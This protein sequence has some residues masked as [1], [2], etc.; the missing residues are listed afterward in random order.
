MTQKTTKEK[1]LDFKLLGRIYKLAKPYKTTLRVAIVLTIIQS[2]FFGIQPYMVQIA[3]DK[4]VAVGDIGGITMMCA[5]MLV[6]LLMQTS[7]MFFTGYLTNLLGQ[8]IIKNLRMYVFDHLMNLKVKFFDTNPV[9]MLITRTVSDIETI[10]EL[11]ASGLVTILGDLFQ[12]IV[13]L[14]CMFTMNWKLALVSLSILPFLLYASHIFR[15]KVKTSFQ[16]VRF[17]ISKLNS[18]IQEHISGMLVVQMFNREKKELDKFV[19]INQDHRDANIRGVFY[20]A[21]FFPVVEIIVALTFAL[22][23]WYGSIGMFNETVEFGQLTAFIMFINL[24]FRPIRAIA[25]RFNNIQMGMVAADRIFKLIDD[26]QYT[27]TQG[28]IKNDKFTNSVEFKDVWL[29]YNEPEYVL[30]GVSFKVNQGETLA[31]VGPTGSGKTS[32]ISLLSRFYDFQ[33]GQILIDDVD[34]QEMDL[35]LLRKNVA[36]VLQDVFLF[37]GSITDNIRLKNEDITQEQIEIAAKSIGAYDFIDSLPG[38]FEYNV[39][40]R[41]AA[42]SLGQ[43]QLISFIR[44]LAFNP[45]L[46]VLDEATSSVDSQT[47]GLIQNAIQLLLKGRTSIV[48]AHRL[49]TIKNADKIIVLEHGK[50]IQVGKHAELLNQEG[51]YKKLYE[52]QYSKVT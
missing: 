11:F 20:Y 49:S 27:E 39:M 52:S 13:I 17:Q 25:D 19:K 23:V 26:N 2:L 18:F 32:I 47:E 44:A 22:L 34:I 38:K 8:N 7:L 21:I 29:A 42:L 31:I 10:A 40:E 48:I 12:I 33:K 36:V 3:L 6:A 50:I 9:G 41:G 5:I 45:S 28:S 51:L 43:R 4:Y 24:F 37:S 35:G 14:I 30:K 15:I 1:T 46:L 16:D